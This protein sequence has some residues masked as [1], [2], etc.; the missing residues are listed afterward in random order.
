MN[1]FTAIQIFKNVVELEGFSAAAQELRISTAAVSKN[2]SNLE[3][4]LG[5]QLLTRTTRRMCATEAGLEYYSRCVKILEDLN[6][7]DQNAMAASEFP[8]GRLRVNAP[9]SFGIRHLSP[10]ITQFLENYEHIEI[11]LELDDKVVSLFDGKF[12]VGIRIGKP[13]LDSSMIARQLSPIKRCLCGSPEYFNKF[14]IPD[15]PMD[16]SDHQCLVYSLSSSPGVWDFKGPE[17]EMQFS[18]NGRYRVNNS[19][20]LRE[21]LIAGLG[22]TLTPT[23]LVDEDLREGRLITVMKDWSPQPL[24]LFVVYSQVRHVPPKVRLFVDYLASKFK[25]NPYW[26]AE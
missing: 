25:E 6:T 12:D 17:G 8:R 24:G 18:V 21:S 22:L 23:F 3:S 4:H 16:L 20:A 2:I 5:V 13:L 7:A 1:K 10:V 26:D 14:G 9:M 11:D 19:L 15:S